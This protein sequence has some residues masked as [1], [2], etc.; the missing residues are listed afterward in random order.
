M[1]NLDEE[2]VSFLEL[3][4]F[5]ANNRQWGMTGGYAFLTDITSVK[6]GSEKRNAVYFQPRGNWEIGN[7]G[8]TEKENA[9]LQDFFYAVKGM[10]IGFRMRDWMDYKD[11]DKGVLRRESDSNLS[12]QMYKK[13]EIKLADVYRLQKIIKPIGPSF[14]SFPDLGNTIQFFWNDEEIFQTTNPS[15]PHTIILDDTKGIIQYNPASLSITVE[16]GIFTSSTDHGLLVND[17]LRFTHNGETVYTYITEVIDS[18]RFRTAYP[19]SITGSI[20]GNPFPT[21]VSN[22]TWTGLFDKAVRFNTDEIQ[23][24]VQLFDE[25]EDGPKIAL[26]LPS[27][28]IIELP[29]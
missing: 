23:P 19:E 16:S 27:I 17:G 12:Y 14:A 29:K 13:R 3:A 8:V 11:D 22:F 9:E 20:T 1:T 7:R 4:R 21:D 15:N 2:N 6:N 24:T 28:Q 25:T 10:L 26:Q 5:D 18:K